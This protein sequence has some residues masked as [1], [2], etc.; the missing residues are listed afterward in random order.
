[1]N[2]GTDGGC[3]SMAARLSMIST[4][5]RHQE[6]LAPDASLSKTLDF[7]KHAAQWAP[8][9]T[10]IQTA[11]AEVQ[12]R[13]A[14]LK[15]SLGQPTAQAIADGLAAIDQALLR[16]PTWPRALAIQGALHALSARTTPLASD[17]ERARSRAERSLLLAAQ[18]NPH[19]KTAYR[20]AYQALTTLR[21]P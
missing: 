2:N 14:R 10:E 1:M 15:L 3:A 18:G 5:W 4:E 13:V 6:R 16:T 9:N 7:A 20:E 19:M 21:S 11:V 8:T 12:W 17:Q